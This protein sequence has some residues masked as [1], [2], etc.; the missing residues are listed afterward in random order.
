MNLKQFIKNFCLP[1]LTTI[2][3]KYMILKYLWKTRDL[4]GDVVEMGCNEGN[5]SVFIQA[6][7]NCISRQKS[8]FLYDSFEG[9]KGATQEQDSA[10]FEEGL[11][12]GAFDSTRCTLNGN[13]LKSSMGGRFPTVV[14]GDIRSLAEDEIPKIIS[15]AYIDL[16]VYAP[17]KYII[18][19]IWNN[20]SVG[21]S[22]VIDDYY[23]GWCAGVKT[24]VDEFIAEQNLTFDIPE[25]SHEA[26]DD[27]WYFKPAEKS[28]WALALTKEK[29]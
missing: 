15:F 4:A 1:D 17:T 18:S 3:R 11:N 26:Q 20:L 10:F 7:I 22:I 9:V 5:V 14:E 21:G 27:Y 25:H 19:K 13:L 12:N 2:D 6:V 23:L 28:G 24:A 29:P 16:D 8:L